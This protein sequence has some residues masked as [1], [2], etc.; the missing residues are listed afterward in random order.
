MGQNSSSN[1]NRLKFASR[2][3]HYAFHP[4]ELKVLKTIAAS[5]H[6]VKRCVHRK[7][8]TEMAVKISNIPHSSSESLSEQL[9]EFNKEIEM[10]KEINNCPN[11]VQFYGIQSSKKKWILKIL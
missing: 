8:G 11:I 3:S 9:A 10:L 1:A 5:N 4:T 7:T 6:V 2:P